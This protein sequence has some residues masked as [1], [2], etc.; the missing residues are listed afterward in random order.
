MKF[1]H[2]FTSP[3]YFEAL[4]TSIGN[5]AYV[6]VAMMVV[7]AALVLLGGGTAAMGWKKQGAEH[8]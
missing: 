5:G 3:H 4:T 1:L 2:D 8:H 7:A 6:V